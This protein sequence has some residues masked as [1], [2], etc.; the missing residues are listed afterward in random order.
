MKNLFPS[1][2]HIFL[3]NIN[4]LSYVFS[5]LNIP[6]KTKPST[7]KDTETNITR[8]FRS[9]IYNNIYIN[10]EIG[11]PKQIVETFLDSKDINFYFSEKTKNDSKTNISNPNHD[12]VGCELD[13][14]FDKSKSNTIE[15]TDKIKS[16]NYGYKGKTSY[17]FFYFK[18][19]NNK[20]I[21][22]KIEF[23][24][25]SSTIGNRPGIIGLQYPRGSENNNFFNLLKQKDIIN[26][27]FW[28]INYT[29]D[30]EGNFIIGELPHKFSPDTY[31]EEDLLIGHPYTY[32][33]MQ[34]YWGLRMDDILF[35]D[36]NFRPYH[37]CYFYQDLNIIEGIQA[38]EKLID[39]YLNDS[40]NN[41]ICFKNYIKYPYGPH[42]FYY[43]NKE[44]YKDKVKEF[45][46]LRFVHQEMNYTFELTYE[47]LFI[48]KYDKLILLIFFEERGSDW[49][50]GK[51]FLKKYSFL[52]NHDM[53]I[54]GFY[55][56]FGKIK[57]ENPN[58]E[59]NSKKN[60]GLTISL[61][62]LGVIVLVALGILIGKYLFK[63]KKRINT[64]DDEYDYSETV[65]ENIIN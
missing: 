33:A 6:F 27:Y 28:M 7:L 54:V 5:Y 40:I 41:G 37:E 53:K 22:E 64:I 52:M 12:D 65:N 21:K 43:C 44:K 29:S 14:F 55:K 18:D 1:L 25:S 51:P 9:L 11:E 17:D 62:V 36:N 42:K 57:E 59:G 31:K 10:L 35:Q 16:L 49:K 20:D 26:S 46:S 24:L 45:P 15:I 32:K 38:L 30:N 34:E 8:L 13:N 4:L 58:N 3:I 2:F 63:K 60:L 50:L 19:E 61:I 56:N 39:K 47:D 23:I 48:E